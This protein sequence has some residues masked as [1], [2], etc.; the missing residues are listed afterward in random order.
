MRSLRRS[1]L[2]ASMLAAAPLTMIAALP[3]SA[4]VS[5]SIGFD[6][7]H[8]ELAPYGDWVYSDRWGEV[9]RP[10]SQDRDRDWRP[11]WAGHWVDTDEYGWT[12]I[13]D[14]G[15]W[16]DIA[17]HYGRWV[18]DPD[19]G[20]L[21]IPGYVWSPAW[22]VWRSSGENVGWM[23][24][25][26]DD[27]FLG[28]GGI[29]IGVS[30]GDWGDIGGYY[31]Y[32]RWYGRDFDD[33][34]FGALWTF[35]PGGRLADPSFRNFAV[36]RTQTINIVRQST[37]ITNYTVV[38]NTI[39]NRSVTPNVV[40]SAGG[41]APQP[42]RANTVLRS[43]RFIAPVNQ[44]EQIQQRARQERPHG[45]GQVNSAPPPTQQQVQS[46]STRAIPVR[47][48]TNA[49]SATPGAAPNNAAPG[50]NNGNRGGGSHLFNRNTVQQFSARQ[51]GQPNAGAA[52]QPNA[53]APGTPQAQQPN[54]SPGGNDNNR[55]R[56][57]RENNGPENRG[58]Q[59]TPNAAAPAGAPNPA[60]RNRE[61]QAQP[62]AAPNTPPQRNRALERQPAQAP[63]AS[64]ATPPTP[65]AEQRG[66][67]RGQDRGQDRNFQRGPQPSEPRPQAVPERA[68][69]PRPEVQ[70]PREQ[71]PPAMEQ[72][73]PQ[74]MPERQMPERQ[75]PER[76][77]PERPMPQ[78]QAAPERPA[79]QP[80][81]QPQRPPEAARPNP[82]PDR[83]ADRNP[84]RG[85]RRGNDNPN[86]D[87]DR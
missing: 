51:Q 14:E 85:Q 40:Q 48:Q 19:D 63:A 11:Y 53:Q 38:N 84:D 27:P 32:S 47:N 50:S 45:N 31:G 72:Q 6:S 24:M 83:G 23:P 76:Q 79:P 18:F 4:Q 82:P 55:G 43:T 69:P 35:V 13:S 68:A 41:R 56:P 59:P 33:A 21:W 16:G 61:P 80:Q 64:P 37:N 73:R 26:P 57:G 29:S 34:R 52:P 70:T 30:F 75:M 36:P 67:D 25:P 9:W 42:V 49:P 3:A 58:A 20:W 17:Y 71:R 44:G 39:I 78:R 2:L 10:L 15:S 66:P 28:R 46:L 8:N 22:V 74:A 65:P 1:L 81:A 12:W 54:A 5:V 86:N 62:N 87:R 60:E 7:F 77:A